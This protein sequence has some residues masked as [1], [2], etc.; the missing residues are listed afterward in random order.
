VK[1]NGAEQIEEMSKQLPQFALLHLVPRV[2]LSLITSLGNCGSVAVALRLRFS[3]M[4]PWCALTFRVRTANFFMKSGKRFQY[5]ILFENGHTF[6]S[7]RRY[8]RR[9]SV[10]LATAAA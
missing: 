3:C 1:L 2:Q 10:R 5:E 8:A 7:W 6:R 4:F 9:A